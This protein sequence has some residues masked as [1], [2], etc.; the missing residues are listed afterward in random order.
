V[1]AQRRD[2]QNGFGLC[3]VLRFAIGQV[4]VAQLHGSQAGL[5]LVD[6]ADDRLCGV[7][8]RRDAPVAQQCAQP[9]ARDGAEHRLRFRLVVVQ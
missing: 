9:P 6:A 5:Q 8:G 3:F 7:S 2:C 4:G 1:Q